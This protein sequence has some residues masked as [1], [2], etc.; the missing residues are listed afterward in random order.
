[1]ELSANANMVGR[2]QGIR[3]RFFLSIA[4]PIQYPAFS[5]EVASEMLDESLPPGGADADVH[6]LCEALIAAERCS[7]S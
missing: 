7:M 1:V 6:V 3:A 5:R 4:D 2:A